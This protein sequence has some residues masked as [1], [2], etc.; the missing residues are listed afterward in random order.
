MRLFNDYKVDGVPILV[1]DSE[2]T[3]TR[4]DIDSEDTGRDESGYMHRIVVRSRV[5]TWEFPYS[6]MTAEEYSYMCG[7]FD[8]KATFTWTYT[9]NGTVKTTDAYC[10]NDS[11]VYQNARTGEY[12]NYKITVI[13]C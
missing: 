9:E 5:K 10:S 2:V 11:I 4:N 8:G 12:R 3:I 7:L 1:P 6:H 13:E